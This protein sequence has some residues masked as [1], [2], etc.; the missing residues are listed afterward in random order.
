MAVVSQFKEN[1]NISGYKGEGL[2]FQRIFSIT[3]CY[4]LLWGCFGTSTP[5]EKPIDSI[6]FK[7]G[8][9]SIYYKNGLKG[10]DTVE[11]ITEG[12]KVG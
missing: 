2:S 3:L 9:D 10:G 4:F 5:G 12:F 11:P 8:L 7:R 1:S 6:Q